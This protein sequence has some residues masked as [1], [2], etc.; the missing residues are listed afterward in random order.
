MGKRLIQATQE[1]HDIFLYVDIRVKFSWNY[2]IHKSKSEQV[3]K[4]TTHP[5]DLLILSNIH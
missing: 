5:V 4:S 1:L 2:Q 3:Y